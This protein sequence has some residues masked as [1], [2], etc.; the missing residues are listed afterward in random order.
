MEYS[1]SEIN[2]IEKEKIKR[3]FITI[4]SLSRILDYDFPERIADRPQ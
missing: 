2:F 1:L 3:L 4:S